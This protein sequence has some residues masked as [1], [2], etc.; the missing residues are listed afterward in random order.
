[1]SDL[2]EFLRARLDE[3]ER[4]AREATDGPWSL[5]NELHVEAIYAPDR[6]TVVVG[7]GRWGD[8]APVFETDED[9]VHI[10][11]HDPARVLREVEAKR[12]TLVRCEEEMLSGI[13]RLVHFAQQTMREMA[14]P[15]ADHPDYPRQ[16]TDDAPC[17]HA[18]DPT[19]FVERSGLMREDARGEE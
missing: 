17:R 1:M 10:V 15:Y 5:D 6:S 14:L 19:R 9:A 2:V 8:E 4:V 11:R 3:D 16:E 7:G 18:A 13:D 12:R